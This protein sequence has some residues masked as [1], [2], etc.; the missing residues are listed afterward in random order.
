MIP[1]LLPWLCFLRIPS[2][3]RLFQLMPLLQEQPQLTPDDL[4]SIHLPALL[5][6][7]Q[8]DFMT[9]AHI[10]EV[11]TAVPTAKTIIVKKAG[12]LSV[13]KRWPEY[14]KE[15]LAFLAGIQ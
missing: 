12:H 15:I 8:R 14:E 4:A 9:K 13:I 11:S 5:V 3:V 1:E 7:A 6:W 10:Q 2:A